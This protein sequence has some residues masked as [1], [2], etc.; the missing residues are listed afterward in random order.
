[1][2]CTSF[3]NESLQSIAANSYLTNVLYLKY[4][5]KLD[6]TLHRLYFRRLAFYKLN[7]LGEMIDN[8]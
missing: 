2:L 7:V 6:Y 4:R 3:T 1:M 8:P 5:Q